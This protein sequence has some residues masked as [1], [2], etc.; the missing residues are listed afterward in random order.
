MNNSNRDMANLLLQ[1]GAFA[2][3][4]YTTYQ[5]IDKI[6]KKGKRTKR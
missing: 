5:E 3:K 6:G 2:W 1:V 4:A